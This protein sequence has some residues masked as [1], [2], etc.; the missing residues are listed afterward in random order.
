MKT[1]TIRFILLFL[2]FAGVSC[3]EKSE[4]KTAAAGKDSWPH[5]VPYLDSTP[6]AKD[7][8]GTASVA[9][10]GPFLAGAMTDFEIAFTVGEAGIAPGGFVILQVSPWWGWTT[11][12]TLDPDGPGYTTVRTSFSD[13]STKAFTLQLGRIVVSSASRGFRHGE[14]ITFNLKDV[15][16]DKFAEAEE[17]F[18]IF[19]DADGDGHSRCIDKPPSVR[20]EAREAVRLEVTAPSQVRPGETIKVG[21]APLDVLGNWSTMPPGRWRLSVIRNGHTVDDIAGEASGEEKRITIP[22]VFAEEGLFFFVVETA[23]RLQ[24][25]SNVVFCRQGEP[26]LNL[27]F[28]DIHGHSRMSDGTGTPGDYY[29]YAR[30]VSGLDIAALTDHADYGTIPIDGAAWERI[31]DAANT[32]YEP[33]EFVTF[34]GFEWTNW[35]YGHRNVYYRDGDG[36]VFRSIDPESDS[37]QELWELLRPYEAMTAAHHVGGGPISTDWS[38]PPGPKE[39]FVEISSIHGTSEFL[40]GDSAVYHP[41]RGAFVRDALARG[42]R[43]GIVGGGDTHDGHPG[44]RSAGAPVTGLMGVY[45]KELTREAV[46]EAFRRRQVYATSGPKIILSFRAGDSPMGSEITW[47]R[48]QGPLPLAFRAICCEKIESVEIIRNGQA[49]FR[50]AGEGLTAQYLLTDPD[51]PS[52]TS[53]YYLRVKQADGNL[54]WSSPVWVTKN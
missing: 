41:V 54:A 19:T 2:F 33:G 44:Q 48:N 37:P 35:K 32:A 27:Y 20:V 46:W 11:P 8:Q 21:A 1:C 52:G 43:L 13:A 28:G 16:V 51:P 18:Q 7:G 38:I 47:S 36:P 53:S 4:M 30:Q 14:T 50:T 12:Q 31:K 10:A 40:G 24:G 42:Y 9:P 29:R 49:V 26:A 22:Y 15:R 39:Y 3:S 25:K 45:A 34:L 5:V 6:S 17:L 23:S